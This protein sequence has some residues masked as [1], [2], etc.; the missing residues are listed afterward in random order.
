MCNVLFKGRLTEIQRVKSTFVAGAT[1][2]RSL[3]T[4]VRST[5]HRRVRAPD[6]HLE[7]QVIAERADE[8]CLEL[9]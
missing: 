8:S 2:S 4:S 3:T 6:R 1:M 5:T 7:V 9:Q